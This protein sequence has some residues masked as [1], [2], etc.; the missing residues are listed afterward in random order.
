[1]HGPLFHVN[2]V[3]RALVPWLASRVIMCTNSLFSK[4]S[5]CRGE[6]YATAGV[7]VNITLQD[8]K[9]GQVTYQQLGCSN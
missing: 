8:L 9:K 2:L 1:M 5:L 4:A 7:P 3:A 6:V